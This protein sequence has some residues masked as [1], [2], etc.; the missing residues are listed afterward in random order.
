MGIYYV[1]GVPYSSDYLM[2]FGIKGQK[3]G[4]RRFQNSDGTLTAAGKER[5][6]SEKEQ[7]KFAEKLMKGRTDMRKT[8][9]VK[10]AVANLEDAV[11]EERIQRKRYDSE[12]EKTSREFYNDK[13]LLDKYTEKSIDKILRD[14]PNVAN[15]F[16]NSRPTNKFNSMSDRD[17]VKWF[18]KNDD[19]GQGDYDP[20]TMFLE[21]G[22]KRAKSLNEAG[23][24]HLKAI[25]N[26]SNKSR[27][28]AKSFLGDY[29]N[30]VYNRSVSGVPNGIKTKAENAVT[31]IIYYAAYDK[32][33]KRYD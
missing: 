23:E 12:F 1:A 13:K 20:F 11:K 22:D 28:Y 24:S 5:Y 15:E 31:N 30:E 2:H 10:H 29:G 19:W 16:R 9:Q 26:M 7:K 21:S 6:G 14:Q 17:V 4:V 3:W 32:Y 18:L 27:E 33:K 8:P 25:R